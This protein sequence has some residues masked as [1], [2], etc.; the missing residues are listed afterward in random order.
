MSLIMYDSVTASQLPA[1]AYAYA[2][3]VDGAYANFE[4]IARTFPHAKLLSITTSGNPGADAHAVD[5]ENG[6]ANNPQAVAFVRA[7]LAERPVA[8]T[9]ASNLLALEDD[10]SVVGPRSS[11]RLWSAHY[12]GVPHLCSRLVCGYGSNTPADATQYAADPYNY[13]M[14]RNIDISVLSE[15]F[16]ASAAVPVPPPVS[17]K[18][19][20][21][22]KPGYFWW[23]V[24]DFGKSLAAFAGS[25]N[26]T[27]EALIAHTLSSPIDGVNKVNFENYVKWNPKG[28]GMMPK[29]LVF[30]TEND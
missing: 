24:V 26:T 5:D 10:L 21:A 15:N 4:E 22:V 28:N 19:P 11:Y 2:G 20:S 9:Q 3:Y 29:G 14:G 6:D 16:F 1:G 8:Y 7:K 18:G 13:T 12:T 27:A 25:R 30:Y 23:E 17:F